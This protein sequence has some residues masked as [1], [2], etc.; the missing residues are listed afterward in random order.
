[1]T[2]TLG[3]IAASILFFFV[4]LALAQTSGPAGAYLGFDFLNSKL[5][6][7]PSP[8]AAFLCGNPSG[9]FMSVDGKPYVSIQGAAGA[10]GPQGVAGPAGAVGPQGPQG[11]TGPQG[12]AGAL[13]PQGP[14]GAPGP[15][16]PAGPTG[17][18]TK[19]DCSGTFDGT[20]W[21]FTNCL[22]H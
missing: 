4:G 6:A 9:I 14:T 3:I 10:A 15:Q 1:M 2:K 21:H 7:S 16:G 13:G 22:P 17:T 12:P 19:L 11:L 8:G 20:L 5:C 18:F